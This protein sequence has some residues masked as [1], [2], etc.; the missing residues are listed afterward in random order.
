M[1]PQGISV[2]GLTGSIFAPPIVTPPQSLPIY[3]HCHAH[4]GGHDIHGRR[5]LSLVEVVL[6]GTHCTLQLDV[7]TGP[8]L[9]ACSPEATNALRADL[10]LVQEEINKGVV[11]QEPEQTNAASGNGKSS[12]ETTTL[13]HSSIKYGTRSRFS[14][15][16]PAGLEA[17]YSLTTGGQYAHVLLRRTSGRLGRRSPTCVSRSPASTN[18]G[19]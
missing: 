6:Q 15:F 14:K 1:V 7:P 19:A 18:T 11:P 10:L 13:T 8:V 17:A 2:L 4:F 3:L 5:R 16:L 9:E 12:A